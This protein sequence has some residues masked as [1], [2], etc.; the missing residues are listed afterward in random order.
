MPNPRQSLSKRTSM[1]GPDL[2][3]QKMR[4]DGLANINITYDERTPRTTYTPSGG[5]YVVTPS[6]L[7]TTPFSLITQ[8]GDNITTQAGDNII[9]N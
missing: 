6:S 1:L 5:A 7:P 4:K 9:T 2:A 8:A 3:L